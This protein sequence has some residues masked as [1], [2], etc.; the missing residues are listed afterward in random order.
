M[1]ATGTIPEGKLLEGGKLQEVEVSDHSSLSPA[2]SPLD[3]IF[4]K[5]NLHWTGVWRL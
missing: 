2:A 5:A 3:I 4:L 1:A